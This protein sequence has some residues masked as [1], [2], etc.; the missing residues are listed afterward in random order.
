[1]TAAVSL[2][3]IIRFLITRL[4]AMAGA[5]TTVTL[6]VPFKTPSELAS[7][8]AVAVVSAKVTTKLGLVLA[9]APDRFTFR[10]LVVESRTI[11]DML[12]P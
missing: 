3:L 1:M 7:V 8:N 9:T 4:V 11:M 12:V 10:L 5:A 2:F 6:L